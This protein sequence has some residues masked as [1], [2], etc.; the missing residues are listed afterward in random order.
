MATAVGG[1]HTFS[2]NFDDYEPYVEKAFNNGQSV[3]R[4]YIKLDHTPNNG[5]VFNIVDG[6]I[7]TYLPNENNEIFVSVEGEV[8]LF[9]FT[10]ETPTGTDL[11]DDNFISDSILADNTSDSV[12]AGLYGAAFAYSRRSDYNMVSEILGFLGDAYLI[13]EKANTFGTQKINELEGKFISAMNDSNE[14]YTEGI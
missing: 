3:K 1:V 14:R 5:V 9:Y 11:G 6:D 12:F 2:E 10:E 8:E 13:T 7:I 4:R